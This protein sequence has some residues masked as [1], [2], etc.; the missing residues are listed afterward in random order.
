MEIAK[1]KRKQEME[2]FA[3]KRA[4]SQLQQEAPETS[5]EAVVETKKNI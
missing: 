1:L 2:R 3:S 5:D 4:G